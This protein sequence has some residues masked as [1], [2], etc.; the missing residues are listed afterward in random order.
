MAINSSLS[1]YVL[2]LYRLIVSGITS[3]AYDLVVASY[4]Y[5]L[6]KTIRAG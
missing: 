4:R 3:L 1:Y 2:N 5:H 6:V